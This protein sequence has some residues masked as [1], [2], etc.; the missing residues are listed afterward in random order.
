MST[1]YASFIEPIEAERATAALLDRGA[2]S[3]DISLLANE[4]YA[5]GVAQAAEA[6]IAV[7]EKD[8]KTG[9]TTTTPA[10]AAMGAV[11]G[12][13]IGT[14]VGIAAA[15]ASLL[16]PG[17][18]LVIGTGALAIAFGGAVG[19]A[20]AGAAAG[21]V[22]GYLKDQGIA[23][24]MASHYS[25]AFESGGAILAVELPTGDL[26][27][28]QVESILVKYGATNIASYAG[29]SVIQDVPEASQVVSDP[30]AAQ[31]P[32]RTNT[33]EFDPTATPSVIDPLTGLVD[34]VIPVSSVRPTRIDPVTG[35]ALEGFVTDPVSG[36]DRAVR[37]ENG[38]VIYVL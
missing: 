30:I 27:D 17:V 4:K 13:S 10:D 18:G 12:M 14:G 9:L 35:Q 25:Q 3:S 15:L 36:I 34:P 2:Q 16:I 26:D 38:R 5:D 22:Y 23:E 21:G 29:P 1:L 24:D 31:V 20:V 7:A 32:V 37:I 11:K 8:A 28:T 6:E 19:T 33:L